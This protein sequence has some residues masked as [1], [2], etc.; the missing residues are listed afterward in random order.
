MGSEYDLSDFLGARA[1]QAEMG[2]RALGYEP[3][4]M[5]GL[6]TRY[7]NRATGAFARITT[8]DGRHSDVTMLPAKDC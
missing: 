5:Q 1:G 3:P 2:L 8:S 6:T 4:R 7:Y